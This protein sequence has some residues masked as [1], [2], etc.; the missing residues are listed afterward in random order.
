MPLLCTTSLVRGLPDRTREFV[1]YH[2]NLGV[3]HMYLFFDDPGEPVIDVLERDPRVTCIRCDDRFWRSVSAPPEHRDA[4][5]LRQNLCSSTALQRARERGFEWIVHLDGDELIWLHQ[6]LDSLLGQRHPSID[7]VLLPLWEAVPG[8]PD[9]AHPFLATRDFKAAPVP[10]RLRRF[11]RLPDP[12]VVVTRWQRSQRRLQLASRLGVRTV[13]N[14]QYYRGASNARYVLRTSAAVDGMEVPRPVIDEDARLEAR[15]ASTAALLHFDAYNF[16][17]W[18]L[19]W[20]YRHDGSGTAQEMRP[21]RVDQSRQIT[22]AMRSGDPDRQR[23]VFRRLHMLSRWESWVLRSMGLLRRIDV[24][25][26]LFEGSLAPPNDE[27]DAA[28]RS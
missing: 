15:V 28:G 7:V 5:E 25:A 19:K 23:R 14:G 16:E 18:K 10:P 21:H 1:Q 17:A 26:S 2:L 6:P 20:R 22:E 3:D 4:I 9:E 8:D 12:P 24:D 11:Y 13:I 27:R